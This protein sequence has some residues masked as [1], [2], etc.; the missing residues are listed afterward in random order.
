MDRN[1]LFVLDIETGEGKTVGSDLRSPTWSPDG[2]RILALDNRE[3]GWPKT[4][5]VLPAEGGE[6]M[7][8]KLGDK[9]PKD[10]H[11][12]QPHW[13]PSGEQIA[14]GKRSSIHEA[15]LLKNILPKK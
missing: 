1:F 5:S 14:F 4:M 10:Y 13:S 2:E 9:L 3:E 8:L 6:G 15:F 11:L 7:E 12:L